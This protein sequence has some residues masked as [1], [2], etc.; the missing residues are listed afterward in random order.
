MILVLHENLIGALPV[1]AE[2]I[3]VRAVVFDYGQV[4]C[5]PQ[6]FDDIKTMA[7]FCQIPI[8]KFERLY[9][10]P[11]LAYDRA[12][13]NAESFWRP[14]LQHSGR[15]LRASD[16]QELVK[17]DGESWGR[18]NKPT[19]AWAQQLADAG[20]TLGILS[21]MPMDLKIHLIQSREWLALFPEKL[22][23]CDVCSVKPEPKIY[24]TLLELLQ[25]TPREVLFLD[26]RPENVEGAREMGIHAIVFENLEDVLAE[27][28]ERFELPV[29]SLQ[30]RQAAAKEV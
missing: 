9:W 30:P 5:L 18:A 25:L 20:L 4:L 22:F 11:R 27:V 21:N 7:D 1:Q 3:R 28:R 14:I 23:S 12:D 19:L 8:E 16:V 29:L 15:A 17:L 6:Q 10:P 24:Q 26:D 13:L 2:K